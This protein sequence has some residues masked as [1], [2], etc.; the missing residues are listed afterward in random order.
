[1]SLIRYQPLEP[2]AWPSLERWSNIRDDLN[3]LFELPSW[4]RF[5]RQG[6]LFGGCSPALDLYED[7]YNIVAVV[8]LPV[9]Q[10]QDI[11]ISPP[12]GTLTISG[13]RKSQTSNR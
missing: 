7:K 2:M 12:D 4:S 9:M 5:A 3:A 11:E 10:N 13:E 6:Q 8:E 1:M